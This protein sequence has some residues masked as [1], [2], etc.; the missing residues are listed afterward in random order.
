M[1]FTFA[2]KKSN[3]EPA[4]T[5]TSTPT[6]QKEVDKKWNVDATPPATGRIVAGASDYTSFEFTDEEKYFILKADKSQLKGNFTLNV[7]DSILTFDGLCTIYIDEITETQITFRLVLT[8]EVTIKSAPATLVS[9]S[10]NTKNLV[11]A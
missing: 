9:S 2:C 3:N 5:N 6:L 8:E 7:G 4:A 1:A 10:Q 11:N